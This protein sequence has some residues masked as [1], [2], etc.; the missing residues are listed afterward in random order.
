MNKYQG[1]LTGVNPNRLRKIAAEE[2]MYAYES[3]T[4]TFVNGQGGEVKT[5]A[6]AIKKNEETE[7]ELKEAWPPQKAIGAKNVSLTE[8]EKKIATMGDPKS[9]GA[10]KAFVEKNKRADIEEEKKRQLRIKN[11][12]KQQW[13]IQDKKLADLPIIKNNINYQKIPN[14]DLKSNM[15]NWIRE[16][17]NEKKQNRIESD[18]SVRRR[19]WDK[20]EKNRAKGKADYEDF[21]I[22]DIR[23]AEDV[24]GIKKLQKEVSDNLNAYLTDAVK[25]KR[26]VNYTHIPTPD[27]IKNPKPKSMGI[28]H[29]ELA[30][31]RKI[32]SEVLN[33]KD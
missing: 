8:V 23:I 33:E 13:G 28:A 16:A 25:D 11:H 30:A 29:P 31:E 3:A 12:T 21:A 10:W 32:I 4:G 22:H 6:E 19:V 15:R 27:F 26:L 14:Q 5:M 7:K 1:Y 20:V 2:K 17:D 24:A 9:N 18:A